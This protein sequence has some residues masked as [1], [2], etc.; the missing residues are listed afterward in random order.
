M[1]FCPNF[2][3][4]RP[5]KSYHGYDPKLLKSKD[6]LATNVDINSEMKNVDVYDLLKDVV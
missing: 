2:F 5:L 4:V 6:V 1:V 3:G